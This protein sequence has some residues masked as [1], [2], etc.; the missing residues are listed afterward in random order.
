MARRNV[1]S[2]NEIDA[3]RARVE[4]YEKVIDYLQDELKKLQAGGSQQIITV[5]TTISDNIGKLPQAAKPVTDRPPVNPGNV[6]P[7]E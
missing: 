1:M 2:H 3:L 6:L 4:K 7:S 5:L